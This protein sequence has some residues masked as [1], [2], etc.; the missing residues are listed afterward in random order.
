MEG[1]CPKS[2]RNKYFYISVSRAKNESGTRLAPTATFPSSS[3][4]DGNS[5]SRVNGSTASSS[6]DSS[7]TQW[8]RGRASQCPY[9]VVLTIEEGTNWRESEIAETSSEMYYNFHPLHTAVQWRTCLQSRTQHGRCGRPIGP[10]DVKFTSTLIPTTV[11]ISTHL[12]LMI[13]RQLL[14]PALPTVSRHNFF[15]D[16]GAAVKEHGA[17]VIVEQCTEL[18]SS[19]RSQRKE[20]RNKDI[21]HKRSAEFIQPHL[22]LV[23]ANGAVGSAPTSFGGYD[24]NGKTTRW[25][26]AP[27]K[28]TN[29]SEVSVKHSGSSVGGQ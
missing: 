2:G 24:G 19:V 10:K 6:F 4:S 12:H 21:L 3:R 5:R 14:G 15:C 7:S 8:C 29:E 20:T 23:L 28:A 25:D 17:R 16:E 11:N 18:R 9:T 13:A 22:Q 27:K 26:S 1:V